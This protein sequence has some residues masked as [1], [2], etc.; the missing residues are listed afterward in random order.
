MST[1]TENKTDLKGGEFLIKESSVESTYIREQITEE[2]QMIEQST[3]DFITNRVYPNIKAIDKQ[4]PGLVVGLLHEI[5][6]LGLLGAAVPEEYGG[7]GVDFA[8]DTFINEQMGKGHSFSAAFAAHTGIGTL[9][10]LY[11]GTEEQKKKYLPGL[12]NSTIKASYCLT[13]PGSGSD[14]LG[15]KTKAVLSEDGKSYIINGQKM[16]ITNA[17]FA[18]LFTVFAKIDG[19]KFT[20]F[21]I[22]AKS[23][24]IS[25]GAEEDKLGIKGSSTR[26]VFFNN[27]KVPVEN[28]LGEIGK[29]HKIAFNVLN[30]GRYKLGVLALGGSKE[31]CTIATKYANERIQFGVPIASFG[32]IKHKLAE[33]ATKIYAVDAATYRTA[34]LIHDYIES[35][36]A[37]GTDKVQAKLLAAEEFSVECAILKVFGSEVLDYVVDEAVQVFGGTGFSEEYPVARAYRDSRINRIFEGTN[38]INRLLSVGMLV[39]KAM[40]GELDLFGP[41]MAVQ[42][43]LM[44]VPDFSTPDADDVFGAERK[45]LLNAKK[46]I[47]MTA[48]AAVQK[49][50]Q[51][52]D[53]E[54]E[55]MMNIADM[56]I[57]LFACESVLLKTEKLIGI[58]GEAACALQIDLTKVYISDSLERI[59]LSGKHAIVSFND[60]DVLRIMLMGLK[61]FTKLDAF[62]TVAARRRIADKVIAENGYCF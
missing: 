22:D 26:Q 32:A 19:E 57:E 55:V 14:A 2:Q 41:A 44:S 61:R 60:G 11:F 45:A 58:K 37:A 24:G 27:V 21:L 46:A 36:T 15:A 25:L 4:E 62:N 7:M 38:E 48:G 20:G 8:T 29:G 39:K 6:E 9:P 34:G 40:K 18:D 49:F 16:W 51:N 33:M 5:A 59:N 10:I 56:L 30:I 28:I 12:A 23:E 43:E 13:E 53:K 50:M 35:A 52:L 42:K 47:L 1:L 31:T 17:G 54:Q 3:S